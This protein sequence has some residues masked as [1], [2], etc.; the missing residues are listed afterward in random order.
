M[1]LKSA[2]VAERSWVSETLKWSSYEIYV[3]NDEVLKQLYNIT[4]LGLFQEI[5]NDIS[6]TDLGMR[7]NNILELAFGII[8]RIEKI[9]RSK[10][11]IWS[12]TLLTPETRSRCCQWKWLISADM[13]LQCLIMKEHKLR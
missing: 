13:G 4:F 6:V 10:K 3:K 2:F 1:V 8:L 7:F 12:T 9:Y 11:L 5:E